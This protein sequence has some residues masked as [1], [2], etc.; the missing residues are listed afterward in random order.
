[1]RDKSMRRFEVLPGQR[2]DDTSDDDWRAFCAHIGWQQPAA[3]PDDYEDRMVARIFGAPDG[4]VVSLDA[5]RALRCEATVESEQEDGADS[6]LT[7]PLLAVGLGV[8]LAVIGAAWLGYQ[9]T[10][11]AMT[12]PAPVPEVTQHAT[13]APE[14]APSVEEEAPPTS[15]DPGARA[16]KV[17]PRIALLR[18][19]TP[20]PGRALEPANAEPAGYALSADADPTAAVDAIAVAHVAV[21]PALAAENDRPIAEPAFALASGQTLPGQTLPG[22]TLPSWLHVGLD[23]P[24]ADMPAGVNLMAHVE[25]GE[26]SR[27]LGQL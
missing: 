19:G 11:A 1:M 2:R 16:R 8:L 10:P 5:E 23:A 22:Q 15:P 3:L 26:V 6:P 20:P 25:L 9:R 21:V 13:V 7:R 4:Q 27:M 18:Q 17:A 24:P 14:P 12:V